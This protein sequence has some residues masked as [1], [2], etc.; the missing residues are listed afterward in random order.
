MLRAAPDELRAPQF[1]DRRHG[2]RRRPAG[3]HGGGDHL[4]L[5]FLLQRKEKRFERLL[6]GEDVIIGTGDGLVGDGQWRCGGL[7]SSCSI[8]CNARGAKKVPDKV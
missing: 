1:L 2:I 5:D 7:L 6:G 3:P 4:H 8:H